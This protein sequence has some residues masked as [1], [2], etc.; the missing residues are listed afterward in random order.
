MVVAGLTRFG[1]GTGSGKAVK[2]LGGEA[3]GG[4]EQ[5]QN[6]LKEERNTVR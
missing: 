6:S 4:G 3:G 5:T 2:I 1:R